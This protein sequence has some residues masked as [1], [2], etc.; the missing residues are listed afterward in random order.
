MLEKDDEGMSEIDHLVL[1][2]MGLT[3]E[4]FLF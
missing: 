1:K 4:W 2:Y 3:D